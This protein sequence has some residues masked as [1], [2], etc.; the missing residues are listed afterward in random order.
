MNP[1]QQRVD[2]YE[3]EKC[4]FCQGNGGAP[5][6]PHPCPACEGKGTIMVHQP[7]I[8][9]PRCSG[10]G[11]AKLNDDLKYRSKLCVVCL[12]TGWVMTELH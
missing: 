5:E 1:K 10:T 11:R 4:G 3:A 6:I 2:S 12:G 8:R 7:P 9:C